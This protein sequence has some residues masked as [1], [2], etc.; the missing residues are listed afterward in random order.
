[1]PRRE[2]RAAKFPPGTSPKVQVLTVTTGQTFIKG[3]PVILASGLLTVVATHPVTA[4]GV[5]LQSAFTNPGNQ[6][7]N[8][9]VLA[10][11]SPIGGRPN[12]ISVAIADRTTIFSGRMVN[13]ATDPVTPL[14]ATDLGTS[15][16]VIVSADNTWAVDQA[17]V[18]QLCVKI[19]GIE[20]QTYA[21]APVV[22]YFVF[23]TPALSA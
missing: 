19:V 23:I 18:T 17:N 5:A 10:A 14:V 16:G 2:F 6:L 3:A 8:A 15:Y 4:L 9:N 7:P 1:V 13:G 11:G 21:A 12:D 22:V 20:P